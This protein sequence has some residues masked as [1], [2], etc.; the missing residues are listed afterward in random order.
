MPSAQMNRLMDDARVRL[1]G[2]LDGTIQAELF[3]AV[4]DFCTRTSV[5]TQEFDIEVVP[6]TVSYL[7]DRDAYTH[8]IFPPTGATS[9]RL[10]YALDQ[11]QVPVMSQMAVPDYVEFAYSPNEATTYKAVIALTVGDPVTRNGEPLAPAWLFEKYGEVFL[12]GVLARMMSQAAKPYTNLPMGAF[13][14]G[15]FNQGV[16]KGRIDALRGN[17]YR[18]QPWRFP[19]AFATS[20]RKGG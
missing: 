17:A 6:V 20:G 14:Q 4:K 13:H 10:M 18:A 1:P 3:R 5:W 2:A 11:N 8:R 9:V 19:Q 16:G 7:E 15:K 12:D